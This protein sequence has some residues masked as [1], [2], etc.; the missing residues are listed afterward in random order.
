MKRAGISDNHSIPSRLVSAKREI[1]EA[2]SS[3]K[4]DK[5][6]HFVGNI[7]TC[8]YNLRPAGNAEE[9]EISCQQPNKT[10]QA[11]DLD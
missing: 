7:T 4:P 11:F 10:P 3:S 5:A 1:L 8:K 2:I 6:N 9:F